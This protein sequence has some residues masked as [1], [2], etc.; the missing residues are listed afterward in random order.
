MAFTRAEA[1]REL[2][3]SQGA[4]DR[5]IRRKE[6]TARRIGRRVLIPRQSLISFLR[7]DH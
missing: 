1:A 2:R 7:R 6:L 4:L 3:I 5:L